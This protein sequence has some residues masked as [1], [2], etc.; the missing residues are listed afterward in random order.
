ML[1]FLWNFIKNDKNLLEKIGIGAAVVI[2]LLWL[3]QG[4]FSLIINILAPVAFLGLI[5]YFGY[6]YLQ[7]RPQK[8]AEAAAPVQTT[9]APVKAAER[10][11]DTSKLEDS[12][13]VIDDGPIE[14]EAPLDLNRLAEK[15]KRAGEVNDAVLAQ[16]EE[17]RRR[18]KDGG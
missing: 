18:L 7:N 17:R 4:F 5:G 11:V 6:R 12:S 16:I 9:A 13:A 14:R 10:P 8:S 1:N 3:L 15:E 2:L